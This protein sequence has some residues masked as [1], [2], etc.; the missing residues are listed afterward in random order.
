VG[1]GVVPQRRNILFLTNRVPFPPDK[2][3]KIRTFH[4]L[5]HLASSHNVYCA[6]FA[7]SDQDLK[8][9][10]ALRRWCTDVVVLRWGRKR[11]MMHAGAALLSR[12]PLTCWAYAC[13]RLSDVLRRWSQRIAFDAVVAFSSSTARYALEVPAGRRVLDLCDV[14]SEKWLN[15]ASATRLPLSWLYKLEGRRLRLFEQACLQAFDATMVITERERV[16]LDP[17]RRCSTLH[18][19]PNGVTLPRTPVPPAC[20]CGPGMGFVGAMDYR[21]NVEGIRWFVREVWPRIVQCVPTARLRIIGRNPTRQVRGLAKHQGVE[22]TGEVQ[23]VRLL[24]GQCR[25]VVTPLRL[26][27]GLQN[28]VLE[29]MALARPVVATSAVARAMPVLP[30]HNILVADSAEEFGRHVVALCDFDALCAKI[31]EGGYRCVATYYSWPEALQRYEE[32]VVGTADAAGMQSPTRSQAVARAPVVAE[33]R[34]GAR[35]P[36]GGGMAVMVAH[37]SSDR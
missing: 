28:K 34:L 25:V 5:E 26:A 1:G 17:Q 27:Q 24:L 31:G 18:V 14:D 11:A 30:G 10:E 20:G 32:L 35:V 9:A 19:V 15:Y 36:V 29:A 6:C 12:E 22:V 16:I 21:P 4:Q 23:D 13:G 2:G 8:H 33:T 3:D 7:D 37:R